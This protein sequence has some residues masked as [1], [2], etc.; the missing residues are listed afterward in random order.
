MG[1]RTGQAW[2]EF[3]QDSVG[4]VE[5]QPAGPVIGARLGVPGRAAGGRMITSTRYFYRPVDRARRQS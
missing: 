5:E 4:E 1:G 3:G 2:V